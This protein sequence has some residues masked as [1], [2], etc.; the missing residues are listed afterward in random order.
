MGWIIILE[1]LDRKSNPTEWN[2]TLWTFY[3]LP[4]TPWQ[5]YFLLLFFTVTLAA[6]SVK[7]ETI[8]EAVFTRW[9]F[10]SYFDVFSKREKIMHFSV[11][12][13]NFMIHK[14]HFI[15]YADKK[16]VVRTR[17]ANVKSNINSYKNLVL[18]KRF[19]LFGQTS[20]TFFH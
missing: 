13:S 10:F 3:G 9:L 16:T 18:C 12:F 20:T 2:I 14:I 11:F 1:Q 5:F 4:F 6:W 19:N 7:K 17:K 8:Y 15:L